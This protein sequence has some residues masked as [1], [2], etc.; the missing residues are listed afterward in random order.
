MGKF[1]L[2]QKTMHTL[3]DR[4]LK[5]MLEAVYAIGY[6]NA[7]EALIKVP[8]PVVELLKRAAG[9]SFRREMEDAERDGEDGSAAD[10]VKAVKKKFPEDKS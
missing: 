10:Y 9:C 7:I 6:G 2:T 4:Q 8:E 3:S 5:E 1:N